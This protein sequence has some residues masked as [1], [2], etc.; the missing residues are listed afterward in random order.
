MQQNRVLPEPN[1]YR[2]LKAAVTATHL[3]AEIAQLTENEK[4]GSLLYALKESE[5]NTRLIE[6]LAQACTQIEP[7]H[8]RTLI[9]MVTSQQIDRQ[10]LEA[11]MELDA[12]I[13]NRT[14][15][16]LGLPLIDRSPVVGASV[17]G[18]P[19]RNFPPPPVVLCAALFS[20]GDHD[21]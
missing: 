18:R 12:P 20:E 3:A 6:Q 13:V 11:F 16:V 17:G 15:P 9:G 7:E 21:R 19:R 2:I 10:N 14:K 1:C 8:T 5:D 4:S